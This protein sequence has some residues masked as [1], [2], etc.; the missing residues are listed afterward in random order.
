VQQSIG[1]ISL[2]QASLARDARIVDAYLYGSVVRSDF[3]SNDSDVDLLVVVADQTDIPGFTEIA[4]NVRGLLPRAD[5]TMLTSREL[6][7]AIHPS[8]S[9]HFFVSVARTGVHLHES[10]LLRSIAARPLVFHETYRNLVQLCQRLRLVI[11][12]PSK[13]PER[14]FWLRKAQHW[15]PCF[16][17]E[18]LHL[19]GS[20]E[21]RLREAQKVFALQLDLAWASIPYP[22]RC[23]EDLH[24]FLE[25]LVDWLP[26]NA[27]KFSRPSTWGDEQPGQISPDLA[28]PRTDSG[29]ASGRRRV[30]GNS[31][32][33]DLGSS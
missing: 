19:H 6:Q 11:I 30:A 26:E 18:L 20:P 22:Y 7:S 28:L 21:R 23:I 9:R 8:G 32:H 27:E 10:D 2:L 33:S 29:T 16:L 15:V 17:M 3:D 1:G 13:R 4:S 14:E 31:R 24:G 5:I 12:N 25:A